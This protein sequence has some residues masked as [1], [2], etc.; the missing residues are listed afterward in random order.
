MI[1]IAPHD[2]LAEVASRQQ[3]LTSPY[4]TFRKQSRVHRHQGALSNGRQRLHTGQVLGP[5]QTRHCA[6]TRGDGPRRHQNRT[7]AGDAQVREPLDKLSQD[8]L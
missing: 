8:H 5:T 6:A 2:K 3:E 7:N 1:G 4:V